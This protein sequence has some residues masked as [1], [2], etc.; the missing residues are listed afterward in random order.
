MTDITALAQSLKAAA[1]NAIGRMNGSQHIHM[2]R[3]SI[4]LSMKV[5]RLISISLISMNSTKKPTR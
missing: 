5:N 3:L 4:S 2:V 1:E